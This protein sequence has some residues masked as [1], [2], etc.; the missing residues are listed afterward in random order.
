MP[1]VYEPPEYNEAIMCPECG[2]KSEV[3]T[4]LYGLFGGGIGPYTMCAHCGQIVTKSFDS[5]E[6]EKP[7]DGEF[8]DVTKNKD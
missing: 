8:T 4:G 1:T 2:E 3:L 6:E 7:I 5:H